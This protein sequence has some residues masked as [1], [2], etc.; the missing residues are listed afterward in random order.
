MDSRLEVCTS[1]RRGILD[2]IVAGHELRSNGD[3]VLVICRVEQ[4][5]RCCQTCY[6]GPEGSECQYWA[7]IAIGCCP[8]RTVKATVN[9]A[10]RLTQPLLFSLL[11][12]LGWQNCGLHWVGWKSTQSTLGDY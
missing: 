10:A 3:T 9:E 2:I 5:D 11:P 4:L 7:I 1:P 12:W 6:S 8:Q